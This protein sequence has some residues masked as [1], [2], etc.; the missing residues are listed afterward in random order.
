M[1]F[2]L[3]SKAAG[4]RRKIIGGKLRRAALLLP[5]AILAIL[6][7]QGA[8]FAEG[9]LAVVPKRIIYPGEELQSSALEEVEVTNPNIAPGYAQ[10][11]SAISG[12]VTKKTLLPGRIILV[13]TLR[14]PYTVSRGSKV[15]L[16]FESGP[17]TI[18]ASGTPLQDAS[19]GELIKVRNT[20]SGVILS[21]TVMA[22]GSV[23]VVAK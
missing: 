9:P 16:V 10:S 5:F 23:H 1:M 4:D 13:S 3:K 12:L 15:H 19:V 20:D 22:D 7:G 8:A 17:L 11:I 6:L 18:T 2:R 21:G 14:Q